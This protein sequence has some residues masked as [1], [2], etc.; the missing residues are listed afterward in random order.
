MDQVSVLIVDKALAA[1]GLI[2]NTAF[3]LGLT[4]GRLLPDVTFGPEVTD[5]DGAKHAFLTNI[6]HYVREAGQ[7]KIQSLRQAFAAMPEVKI[8]DYTEDAAPAD[9]AAYTQSLANHKGEAIKYR[10]IH[11]YG[12]ADKI[13]PL[14]KNLSRL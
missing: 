3:V 11:L 6:G 10:A 1:P 12:P 9:Y 8:I 2:A 14:T 13:V 4:A 5:G 7:S